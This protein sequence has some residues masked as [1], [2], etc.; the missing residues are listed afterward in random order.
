MIVCPRCQHV[1]QDSEEA[2][3]WQCPACGVA[4]AKVAARTFESEQ[5]SPA[6]PATTV[7]TTPVGGLPWLKLVLVCVLAWAAWAG[8][9]AVGGRDH[10][11]AAPEDVRSLAESVRA[12]EIV[13]Y[14][15]TECP[16]CAQTR[17]W[18]RGH[19]FRFTECN[20]SLSQ[21]CEREYLSYG[22]NG[23]PYL[24][25]RGHHMKSGFDSD[26]FLADLRG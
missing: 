6:T 19:G 2:P 13:M 11:S 9:K 17:A 18:L 25:V 23:T 5:M 12:D 24:I 1:R 10:D 3:A 16:Y 15:T 21:A 7:S 14:S 4:Y 26:E 8:M 22:G 20:M